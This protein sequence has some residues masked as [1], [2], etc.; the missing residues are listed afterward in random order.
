MKRWIAL[1]LL[2][3]FTIG[4]AQVRVRRHDSAPA[5][6]ESREYALSSFVLGFVPATR[7]PPESALCQGGRIESLDFFSSGTDV[8]I[9]VATLG[10]Y[11]PHRVTVGCSK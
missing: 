5:R 9:G 6:V 2:F 3:A 4:C 8:L 7:L 1:S 11:V 10:I